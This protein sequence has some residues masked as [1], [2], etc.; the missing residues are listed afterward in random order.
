MFVLESMPARHGLADG[1]VSVGGNH[2]GQERR[3]IDRP[4]RKAVPQLYPQVSNQR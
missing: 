1:L 3:G 2:D 4:E